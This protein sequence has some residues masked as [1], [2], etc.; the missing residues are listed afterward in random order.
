MLKTLAI[1]TGIAA[2]AGT[3][4]AETLRPMQALATSIGEASA[5]TYYTVEPEGYRVVTTIRSGGQPMRFVAVLAS[6]QR[7]SIAVARAEGL[8]PIELTISRAPDGVH[9]DA[10]QLTPTN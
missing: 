2:I 10:Q 8:A 5:V 3:A 9:V 1:A 4:H 7:T 6:G